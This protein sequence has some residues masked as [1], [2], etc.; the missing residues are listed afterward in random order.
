MTKQQLTW[1]TESAVEIEAQPA[2]KTSP[3]FQ[4]AGAQARHRKI[5][6]ALPTLPRR[7]PCITRRAMLAALREAELNEWQATGGD[8]LSSAMH[9]PVS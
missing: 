5:R 6:I 8:V 3:L 7:Q 4:S 2:R 9:Q 1:N